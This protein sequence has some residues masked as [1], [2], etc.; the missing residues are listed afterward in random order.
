MDQSPEDKLV[1]TA[2]GYQEED[3]IQSNQDN[4]FD[5]IGLHAFHEEADTRIVLHA[6]HCNRNK[7]ME[8]IV[9]SARDTDVLLILLAQYALIQCSVWMMAG[10]S[11]K[12][13]YIPIHEV[14]N[15]LPVTCIRALLPFHSITGCDTT[16]FFYGHSKKATFKIFIKNHELIQDIGEHELTATKLLKAEKFICKIYNSASDRTDKARL[17]MYHKCNLPELLPPTSD[18]MDLHIKRAH[19]QALVWKQADCEEPVLPSAEESGWKLLNNRLTPILM[20]KSPIPAACMEMVCCG[21]KK[22]CRSMRCKC[23]KSNLLCTKMCKCENDMDT[24]CI[25]KAL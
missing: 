21:C 23:R 16:S 9:V 10:T 17:E 3:A 8:T 18:A 15:S 7:N 20:M 13:K 11:K 22:G 14:Y 19:F 6:I 5:D 25:N 24:E 4:H 2:G 1:V 12:Q